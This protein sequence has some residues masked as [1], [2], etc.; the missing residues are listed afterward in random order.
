MTSIT[1]A[2]WKF[3]GQQEQRRACD[4]APTCKAN[5]PSP[6]QLMKSP[7]GCGGV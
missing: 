6:M 4:D 7:A 2:I 5:S 3:A 1:R